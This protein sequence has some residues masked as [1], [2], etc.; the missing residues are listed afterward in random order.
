MCRGRAEAGDRGTECAG[1]FHKA[2]VGAAAEQVGRVLVVNACIRGTTH[3]PE[4]R[5]KARGGPLTLNTSL[6]LGRLR[7]LVALARD[8]T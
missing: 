8:P 3:S 7:H 6:A 5:G 1:D 4:P 2:E